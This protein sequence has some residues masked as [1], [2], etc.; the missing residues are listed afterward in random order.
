M[1]TNYLKMIGMAFAGIGM[2]CSFAAEIANSKASSQEMDELIE[3]K[4]NKKFA[5]K[6]E[7]Q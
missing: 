3:D 5:E 1:K 6:Y 7:G 2:L 4:V